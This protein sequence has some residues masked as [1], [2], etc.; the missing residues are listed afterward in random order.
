M[1][2]GVLPGRGGDDRRRASGVSTDD[3]LAR[4]GDRLVGIAGIFS[5]ERTTIMIT[6]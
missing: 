4:N 2:A 1:V 3:N 5:V 6:S